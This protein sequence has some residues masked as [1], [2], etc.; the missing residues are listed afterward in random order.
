MSMLS[1]PWFE[2]ETC[3]INPFFKLRKIN[4]RIN[5]FSIWKSWYEIL[6]KHK[7][8]RFYLKI[9]PGRGTS[10]HIMCSSV[11]EAEILLLS[12][13]FGI[14]VS[15]GIFIP[16]IRDFFQSRDFYPRDSGFFLVSGFLSPGFGIF[17]VSG[18]LS[19]GFGIFL[20]FGI[21]IPGIFAKSPGFMENPRNS[22]FFR[23]FLP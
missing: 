8:Q 14:F 2:P 16:G 1:Y 17:S 22:G 12:P 7:K 10:H 21:F 11:L 5:L 9:S 13:G 4:C 23:D 15:L 18:F 6:D 3:N 19:P 20:N